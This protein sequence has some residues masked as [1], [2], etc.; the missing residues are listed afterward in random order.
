MSFSIPF[1]SLTEELKTQIA[2]EC[3][4]KP[5]PSQYEEDPKPIQIF[6]VDKEAK[7]VFIPLG[8][9]KNYTDE[10]PNDF[11]Y[12]GIG[13][14]GTIP[15]FTKETDPKNYRDQDVVYEQAMNQLNDDGYVFLNLAT[16]FGKTC[17]GTQLSAGCGLKTL[18]ICH[19]DK[20]N[21]Q[22][23]ESFRKFTD[24]KVQLV[25][26]K[27]DMTADVLVMGI[28]KAY[29]L[30]DKLPMIGTVI[31]D[32]SHISTTSAATGILLHIQPAYLIGLS[33]TPHR[34][35]GLH[36]LFDLFFEDPK[37]FIVRFE[38][39]DFVVIKYKTK[40]K[41]EVTYSLVKGKSTMNWTNVKNSL[42]YNKERQLEIV[43]LIR[44]YN[45]KKIMVLIDRIQSC[46][47]IIVTLEERGES[48]T[49]LYGNIKKH[50]SDARVL[51]A[52]T[53]KAGVGFD[54][55]GL[56]MLIITSDVKTVAQWEGR[57]RCSNNLII[58]MVDDFRTLEN[59]WNIREKWYR[60][61]GAEIQYHGEKRMISKEKKPP[62]RML[63][64]H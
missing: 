11:E 64:S 62:L 60:K 47:D 5:K 38:T 22:W 12:D 43:E 57:I 37:K 53:S 56:N 25:K 9:W 28:K 3:T 13:V 42:S 8:L 23:V 49:G 18:V 61:R 30:R 6:R 29:N 32:E 58:D 24:A 10:F 4:I 16:G 44:K 39:K 21:Q 1:S 35:D 48:V 34:P 41:P 40:Y 51:V 50:D 20:V 59:H 27:I 2:K 31:F 52:T 14:K 63:G 19:L 54:Q 7:R 33:A 26:T 36:S 45:D 17:L 46:K 15:L 55:P